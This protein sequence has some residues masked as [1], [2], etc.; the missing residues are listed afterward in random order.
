MSLGDWMPPHDRAG[1]VSFWTAYET[2]SPGGKV[3][4]VTKRLIPL[5]LAVGAVFAW[6][7]ILN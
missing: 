7:S 4:I 2:A 6:R 3:M 1:L 5:V